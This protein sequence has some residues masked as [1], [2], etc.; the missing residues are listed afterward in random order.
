[1]KKTLSQYDEIVRRCKSLFLKKN[2]DYGTA[3]TILRPSSVTDQCLIKAARIRS[4]QEREINVVGDSVEDEFVGI[5]NYSIIALIQWNEAVNN[6]EDIPTDELSMMYDR[7]INQTKELMVAKNSD[8]GEV[9]RE[10]RVSSI[11]DMILQ[12]IRR[13]RQIEN[14]SGKTLVSEG[15][16]ANYSDMINYA[17]FA[18]I[19]LSEQI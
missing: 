16:D 15:I 19:L 8:Y 2:T 12:K 3:W 6:R 14:Q 10:M 1:M 4:I 11:T 5:I 18:L 7:Q 9:W 13:I 17:I